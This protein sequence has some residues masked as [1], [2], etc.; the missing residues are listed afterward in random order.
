MCFNSK[1]VLVVLTFLK[2]P[3]SVF[4]FCQTA[5]IGQFSQSIV[6][7][8]CVYCGT[9]IQQWM[10]IVDNFHYIRVLQIQ[11]IHYFFQ[12]SF[13]ILIV[14]LFVKTTYTYIYTYKQHMYIPA[15]KNIQI[16]CICIVY[17]CIEIKQYWYPDIL[18]KAAK[19]WIK[20]N[21]YAI[22]L[23]SMIIL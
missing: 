12:W 6:S 3:N 14:F 16:V 21:Y 22:N 20:L 5:T 23:E 19:V 9:K 8:Y 17:V 15:Y 13:H 11:N 1:I 4:S 7:L 2:N 18:E 10:L